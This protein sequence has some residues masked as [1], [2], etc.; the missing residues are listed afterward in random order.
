MITARRR[1]V[2]AISGSGTIVYLQL[3]VSYKNLRIPSPVWISG[4][5]TESD[6]GGI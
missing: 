6:I 5:G 2:A 3:R 1:L 4:P